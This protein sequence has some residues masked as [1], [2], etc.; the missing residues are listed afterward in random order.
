M[1]WTTPK[2]WATD[3]ILT[4]ADLNTYVRD[5]L[6]MTS[7]ATVTTAGDIAYADGP[8][9]MGSR[10]AI[11]SNQSVMFSDGTDPGWRFLSTRSASPADYN[12]GVFATW[13]QWGTQE[14]TAA[15]PDGTNVRVLAWLNGE[16]D[17]QNGTAAASYQGRCRVAVSY[18]NGSSWT[19]GSSGGP[20]EILNTIG[21]R[22]S[23]VTAV[24]A[25]TGTVSAGGLQVRAEAYEADTGE[26]VGDID[27]QS[28]ELTV[29]IIPD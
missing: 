17:C 23:T 3:D 8:N 10:L 28:A 19:N 16:I 13:E 2:T 21:H 15:G 25:G 14:A 29:L 27:F 18:D 1:A 9:S 26:T 5:N 7:A 6:N 22:Q 12:V 11:G 4:A 24:F 20:N